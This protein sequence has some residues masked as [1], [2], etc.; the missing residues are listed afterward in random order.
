M[1]KADI[2]NTTANIK[3]SNIFFEAAYFGASSFEFL[4][5]NTIIKLAINS[6]ILSFNSGFENTKLK[7]STL[8]GIK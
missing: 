2:I 8:A 1:D 6:I 7:L 4:K 5:Q 3:V